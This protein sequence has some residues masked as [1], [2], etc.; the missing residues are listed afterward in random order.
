MDIKN[1]ENRMKEWIVEDRKIEMALGR[2]GIKTITT[3]LHSR[4]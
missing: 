1:E 2:K 3:S 4:Q